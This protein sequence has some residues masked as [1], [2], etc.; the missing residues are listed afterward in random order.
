MAIRYRLLPRAETDFFNIY[1]Y[2]HSAFG[3][4]QADKY[5]EGLIDAFTRITEYQRIGRDVSH[6]RPGYFRYEFKSHSIYYRL[7]QDRVTI[8]RILGQKQ[9]PLRHV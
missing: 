4:A 8:I 7:E 5:T 1:A 6:I 3:A 9:D 2:T